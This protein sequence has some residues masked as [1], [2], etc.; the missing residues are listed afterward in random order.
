MRC[1]IIFFA[2][3]SDEC[4][5]RLTRYAVVIIRRRLNERDFCRRSEEWP[6]ERETS[7]NLVCLRIALLNCTRAVYASISDRCFTAV[8]ARAIHRRRLL[9]SHVFTD[10][11][12]RDVSVIQ[13]DIKAPSLAGCVQREE[14]KKKSG[15]IR[16]AGEPR[17]PNGTLEIARG[18]ESMN[19]RSID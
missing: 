17:S 14:R 10:R 16:A 11:Q 9:S 4:G 19:T 13:G 12:L 1:F 8:V 2:R 5:T 6:R 18:I 15:K 3:C 7:S